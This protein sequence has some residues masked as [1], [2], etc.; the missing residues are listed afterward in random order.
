MS[1][2]NSNISFIYCILVDLPM[3]QIIAKTLYMLLWL[4]IYHSWLS[5]FSSLSFK[6]YVYVFHFYATFSNPYVFPSMCFPPTF[7]VFFLLKDLRVSIIP[8]HSKMFLGSPLWNYFSSFP[9]EP[10]V[11]MFQYLLLPLQ[12]L[13]VSIF[14][15]SSHS[16]I[17]LLLFPLCVFFSFKHC[18]CFKNS[19]S[20]CVF[21]SL[22]HCLCG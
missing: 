6:P 4:S 21:F 3:S 18:M 16:N 20:L 1:Q 11:S 8:S 14:V 2:K 10:Y 13:Y 15:F 5:N 7:F 17:A 22:I 9:F 19:N 12:P